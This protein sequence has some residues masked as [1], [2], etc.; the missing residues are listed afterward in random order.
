MWV[1]LVD[2][3]GSMSEGFTESAKQATFLDRRTQQ[4]IKLQAA[5]ESVL[6]ELPRLPAR[7]DVILFGFTSSARVLYQGRAGDQAGFE[8][9]LRGLSRGRRH[10]YRGGAG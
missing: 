6:I 10:R 7:S 1:I 5:V 8:T 3:S 4:A 2:H 9:A